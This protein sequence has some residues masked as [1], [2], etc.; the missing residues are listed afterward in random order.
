VPGQCG[1]DAVAGAAE[2]DQAD[3]VD[4]A[5]GLHRDAVLAGVLGAYRLG[6]RAGRAL[7]ARP[8][9]S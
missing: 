6:A 9:G 2:A 3:R 1:C 7:P 8:F 5:L 4:D